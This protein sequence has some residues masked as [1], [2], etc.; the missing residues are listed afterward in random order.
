MTQEKKEAVIQLVLRLGL[1]ASVAVVVGTTVLTAV[2]FLAVAASAL[3]TAAAAL[4]SVLCVPVLIR[5]LHP[6]IS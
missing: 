1:T 3:T 5:K 2:Q 4:V 6:V